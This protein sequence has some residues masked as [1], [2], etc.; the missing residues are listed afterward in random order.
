MRYSLV[1]YE[2]AP[3]QVR[4]IYDDYLSSTG[5]T[6]VPIWVQSLGSNPPLLHAYWERTRGSLLVGDLPLLLKEMVVFVVSVENGSRYCSAA[7]AHSVLSMDS[8]LDYDRLLSLTTPGDNSAGLPSSYRA[9]LDYAIK[10][11]RDANTITDADFE[12]LLDEDFTDEEIH[13]L[14]SV[15]DLAMMFN[16]YTSARRLPL[17]SEYRSILEPIVA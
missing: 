13:E 1:P 11:A 6:A 4:A 2:S 3:P 7:H 14:Q 12:D 5:S 17:D 9:A 15:I 10:V 8:T 16:S